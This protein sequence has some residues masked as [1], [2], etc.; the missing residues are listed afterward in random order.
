MD[1]S[2]VKTLLYGRA[3]R[4]KLMK[5][6]I[7]VVVILLVLVF[8]ILFIFKKT[9]ESKNT[10]KNFNMMRTYFVNRG[11]TCEM[12]EKSGGQC[13]LRGKNVQYVFTRYDE[14]FN[15][16]MKSSSYTIEI[17]H[18][19][20]TYNDIKLTTNSSAL[21]GDKNR[22]FTC[23]TNDGLLG[24]VNSCVDNNNGNVINEVYLGAVQTAINNVNEIINSS[25]YKRDKI[26]NEYVWKI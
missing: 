4:I 17:R 19:V 23:T 10:N 18:I 5:Q 6:I 16:L 3:R 25:G 8:G 22:E 14:G 26:I 12:I 1:K 13:N 21:E 24:E 7:L 20:N 9:T 15:Y 11:Y 2:N